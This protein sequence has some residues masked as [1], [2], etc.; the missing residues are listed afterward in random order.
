M[1]EVAG[2]IPAPV[3][4]FQVRGGV[5]RAKSILQPSVWEFPPYVQDLELLRMTT[6]FSTPIT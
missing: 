2:T 3:I 5:A 6:Y 1:P 4:I